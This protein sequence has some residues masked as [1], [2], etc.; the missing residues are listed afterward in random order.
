MCFSL[1]RCRF[2]T[3]GILRNN[4]CIESLFF[5]SSDVFNC[6]QN[7]KETVFISIFSELW[8]LWHFKRSNVVVKETLGEAC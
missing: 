8:L 4:T 7:Y 3:F 2:S 5:R 1:N 6:V